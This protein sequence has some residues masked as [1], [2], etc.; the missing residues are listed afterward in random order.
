VQI[1]SSYP[2]PLPLPLP[3]PV[4]PR[5]YRSVTAKPGLKNVPP[6]VDNIPVN[7]NKRSIRK[8]PESKRASTAST[9]GE[10]STEA[11]T[12]NAERIGKAAGAVWNKLHARAKDGVSL[13]DLKKVTGFTADEALAG[14]GWLAREGKLSFETQGKKSVVKL[15]HEE[16]YV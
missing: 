8:M 9:A 12:L 16:V 7:R 14:I 6:E 1:V 2:L 10:T 4:L 13:T 3:L 11:S 15:V 5:D